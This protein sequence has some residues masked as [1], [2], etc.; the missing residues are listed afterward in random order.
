[1]Q[2]KDLATAYLC[3]DDALILECL[4]EVLRV[5]S[6]SIN[7]IQHNRS[8]DFRCLEQWAAEIS[9]H[10]R[11][12]E[13]ISAPARMILEHILECKY[14]GAQIA[15]EAGQLSMR[16]ASVLKI[17]VEDFGLIKL[18]LGELDLV[19]RDADYKYYFYPDKVE[20][21]AID[22]KSAIKLFFS[23]AFSKQHVSRFSQLTKASNV[24]YIHPQIEQWI[25]KGTSLNE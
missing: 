5:I 19:W 13:E 14:K 9:D 7:N 3:S 8:I 18:R 22:E 23:M 21:R 6:G 10:R 16:S 2:R 1:M 25:R 20:L 17:R 11:I 4:E 15:V 12:I 24:V